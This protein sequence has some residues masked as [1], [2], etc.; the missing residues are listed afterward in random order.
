MDRKEFIKL[1]SISAVGITAGASLLPTRE[2]K[3]KTQFAIK[4]G[5]GLIEQIENCNIQYYKAMT[6]IEFNLFINKYL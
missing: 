6:N 2:E 1:L 5:S 4:S 3:P